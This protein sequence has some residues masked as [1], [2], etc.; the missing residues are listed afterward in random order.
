MWAHVEEEAVGVFGRNDREPSR[1][2]CERMTYTLAVLKESLRKYSV[3]PVV[4]RVALKD[5]DDLCG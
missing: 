5:D 4:V 2:A 1:E 3:V